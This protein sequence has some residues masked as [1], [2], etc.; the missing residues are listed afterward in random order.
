MLAVRVTDAPEFAVGTPEVLFE[1][2]YYHDDFSMRLANYDVDG[3]GFVMVAL[4][5]DY[6]PSITVVQNWFEELKRL[7]PVD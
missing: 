7:V 5:C 6:A 3:Q 2:K 4:P 1:G